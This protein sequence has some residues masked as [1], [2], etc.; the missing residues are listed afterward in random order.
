MA[1]VPVVRS[2]IT[3]SLGLL[4]SAWLVVSAA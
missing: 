1:L 2:T 4:T 3:S